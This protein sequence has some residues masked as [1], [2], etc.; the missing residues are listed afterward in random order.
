MAADGSL[1]ASLTID[2]MT[3]DPTSISRIASYAL[4]SYIGERWDEAVGAILKATLSGA[5]SRRSGAPSASPG[6]AWISGG[7][8]A[9]RYPPEIGAAP[10]LRC[11]DELPPRSAG[12]HAAPAPALPHGSQVA[13]F[14]KKNRYSGIVV[15]P[16]RP[17]Q[18][19]DPQVRHQ[20]RLR[21]YRSS[22]PG[23]LVA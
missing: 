14:S 16:D 12:R 17:S 8:R 7:C 3:A 1:K 2:Q 4:W 13:F 18:T 11:G 6:A 15:G 22:T 23:Q 10:G 21:D 20:Q 9:E 19:A 5:S